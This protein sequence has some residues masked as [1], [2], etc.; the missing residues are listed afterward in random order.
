MLIYRDASVLC[1]TDELFVTSQ[2]DFPFVISFVVF[3]DLNFRTDFILYVFSI[4][5]QNQSEYF[6][7]SYHSANESACQDRSALHTA[8]Y[9]YSIGTLPT[10]QPQRHTIIEA[11]WVVVERTPRS[12]PPEPRRL[13]LFS[14]LCPDV[15]ATSNDL[16]LSHIK[17]TMIGLIKGL[18]NRVGFK[19]EKASYHQNEAQDHAYT[20]RHQTTC[21]DCH[22]HYGSD[23]F[24]HRVA[25]SRHGLL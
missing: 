16:R 18:V 20:A 6:S 14:R 3:Q 7:L 11:G 4:T 9:R 23:Q 8:M 15:I 21:G 5:R 24:Y 22:H 13:S 19:K 25:E 10:S 12:L 1:E 2:D 17:H